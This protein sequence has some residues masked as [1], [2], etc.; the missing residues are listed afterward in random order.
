MSKKD[1]VLIA[2]VLATT[3]RVEATSRKVLAEAFA[4]AIE[5]RE[6]AFD[7]EH[8]LAAALKYD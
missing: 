2:A 8:F 5:Q 3:P 7:R 1:Y 4:D 6:P